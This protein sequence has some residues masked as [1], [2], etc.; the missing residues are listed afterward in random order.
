M[1]VRAQPV[2]VDID[3]EHLR[4]RPADVIS[5]TRER[6]KWIA[7]LYVPQP[8]EKKAG[9]EGPIS[10][11]LAARQLYVY[12]TGGSPSPGELAARRDEATMAASWSSSR[13]P[14]LVSFRVLSDVE[15]KDADWKNAN[16]IL[17]GNKE[18][19]SQIAK[20]APQAPVALNAGAADYGLV[21]IMPTASD[22]Y[23]VIN[24]GLPWWTRADQALRAGLSLNPSPFRHSE[25]SFFSKAD[26]ITWWPRDTSI[27]SGSSLRMSLPKSGQPAR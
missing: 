1:I 10:Q 14:L 15:V 12:G 27:S 18:T 5:F 20:L 4:A 17:F 26:W 2:L 13:S 11:A 16:L 25:I 21:F 19:N 6:G 8:H 3:G 7:K 23:A 24:S 9:N 22:H